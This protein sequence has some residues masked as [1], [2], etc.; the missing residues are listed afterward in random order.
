MS[1]SERE[2]ERE[3]EGSKWNERKQGKEGRVGKR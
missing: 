1:K 3:R 2:R